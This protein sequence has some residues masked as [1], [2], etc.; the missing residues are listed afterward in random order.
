MLC[1][2][3]TSVKKKQLFLF[4]FLYLDTFIVLTLLFH[5]FFGLC[6]PERPLCVDTELLAFR[7]THPLFFPF[8]PSLSLPQ[9]SSPAPISPI[10]AIPPHSTPCPLPQPH[11]QLPLPAPRALP[12]LS[13]R[14]RT[15]FSPLSP[16]FPLFPVSTKATMASGAILSGLDCLVVAMEEAVAR[17]AAEASIAASTTSQP[18]TVGSTTS[19]PLPP[20]PSSKVKQKQSNQ[21]SPT[22]NNNPNPNHIPVSSS[23]NGSTTN[24]A[25]KKTSGGKR[26]VNS[27]TNGTNSTAVQGF[28]CPHPGCGRVFSKRY[29]QQAHMRIHDG[30]RPFL[31]ALC[32]KR[33]MWK[34]S[35]KS[36]AKMHAKSQA[37]HN[38]N[39]TSNTNLKSPAPGISKSTWT[40]KRKRKH[41]PQVQV[42]N[43]DK[44]E[45]TSLSSSSPS[46]SSSSFS[47]ERKDTTT[48]DKKEESCA[49][50]PHDSKVE[51]EASLMHVSSLSPDSVSRID[52]DV[53]TTL[54]MFNR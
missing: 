50:V 16:P 35:L 10:L 51:K 38:M 36:H 48:H 54:T 18:A 43:N 14:R 5:L 37:L 26:I 31:C 45:S 17:E 34:S 46:S 41:Q 11:R 30:T 7:L 49:V 25:A 39:T 1:F 13:R 29:N 22:T 27:T 24:T 3:W 9:P 42:D 33:F 19:N 2:H 20:S 15:S 23:G 32:G 53:A 52:H 44:N 21:S 8:Y 47:I 6:F 40:Q 28:M 4:I 12:A